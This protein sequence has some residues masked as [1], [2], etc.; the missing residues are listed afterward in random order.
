MHATRNA[1]SFADST[2]TP[3]NTCNI[4]PDA[5]LDS[6]AGMPA[7][8]TMAPHCLRQCSHLSLQEAQLECAKARLKDPEVECDHECCL[9]ESCSTAREEKTRDGDSSKEPSSIVLKTFKPHRSFSLRLAKNSSRAKEQDSSFTNGTSKAHF[10]CTNYPCVQ[11]ASRPDPRQK[12]N[13][14]QVNS[15]SKTPTGRTNLDLCVSCQSLAPRS[16]SD[17][18][19]TDDEHRQ[20]HQWD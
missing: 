12:N 1:P 14:L 9:L 6:D 19:D 18:H 2:T 15:V 11:H 5:E 8:H 16:S 13:H 4:P 10:T 17:H 3:S 7:E 20:R